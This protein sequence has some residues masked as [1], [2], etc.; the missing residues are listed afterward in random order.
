[1]KLKL[2]IITIN[3]N[4]ANG[5]K[6]TIGSVAAQTSSDFEY[7]VI[8][9]GSTDESVDVICEFEDHID[10]WVSEQDRGIYH[11]MNKGIALAKGDYCQFLNSGDKLVGPDVTKQMLIE[12]QRTNGCSILIGNMLKELPSGK[13]YRDK[14]IENR[15]P[16]F[17]DFYCGTLNHSPAYIEKSLFNKFGNYDESLQIVSDWKWYLIAVGL[18][19]ERVHFIDID[20]TLFDM[21]GISNTRLGLLNSEKKNVLLQHIPKA[22]LTDYEAYAFQMSQ[23]KRMNKYRLFKYSFWL[24]E[25]TL[26]KLEKWYNGIVQSKVF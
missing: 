10:Q 26:F 4:N 11:A 20:V 7:L 19:N 15:Q 24:I 22:I 21:S 9:G 17:Y 6:K 16:T 3:Y 23:I 18:N 5:L 8:D 2:T 1:M 13:I 12:I 14:Y 25:R